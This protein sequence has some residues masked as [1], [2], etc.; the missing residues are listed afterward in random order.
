MGMYHLLQKIVVERL[1]AGDRCRFVSPCESDYFAGMP[2]GF[3][4]LFLAGFVGQDMLHD[5][6]LYVRPTELHPGAANEIY[7][8]RTAELHA[9]IDRQDSAIRSR[10][11]AVTQVVT[12]RL[13]GIRRLLQAAAAEFAAVHGD[14]VLPV[15]QLVG[16]IYVRNDAFANDGVIAKLEARGV[17]VRCAAVNEWFGYTDHCNQQIDPPGKIDRVIN[18]LKERIRHVAW[19]A[20]ASHLPLPEPVSVTD[21]A[22]AA[23]DY[24]AGDVGGETV[25]TLGWSLHNWRKGEIAAVVNVGPLECM[26]TRIA[27]S[28]FFHAAEREG[29]PTL[30]LT[31][32]GDPLAEDV[33]DNFAFE[34]H[35]R[36]RAGKPGSS[37]TVAPLGKW[38]TGVPE[39]LCNSGCET[40][41][42]QRAVNGQPFP[43]VSMSCNESVGFGWPAQS[44]VP[45]TLLVWHGEGHEFIPTKRL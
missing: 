32:N 2:P 39:E 5:A 35:A 8:R 15:V 4:T 37:K 1:G 42:Y 9:L 29:L 12:G 10:A 41:S 6:L 16:E 36:H 45:T 27:E 28:Q 40:N 33:L 44:V 21:I 13:F 11:Q 22:D 18:F 20:M 3:T 19:E 34:V 14:R 43:F 25:L 26:P 30:T 24:I 31:F 7:A 17:R 23:I 38:R